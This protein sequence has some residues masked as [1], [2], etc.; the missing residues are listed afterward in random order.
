MMPENVYGA[1]APAASEW[2]QWVK[3]VLFAHLPVTFDASA[4]VL[5]DNSIAQRLPSS[6]GATALVLDLPG[7]LGAQMAGPLAERGYRPVP[8]YNS[9]P[10]PAWMGQSESIGSFS[11]S[12][13]GPPVGRAAVDVLPILQALQKNAPLLQSPR[14]PPDAPPAFLL[15]ANRRLGQIG[16]ISE[17]GAFDNR[18][19]SLPTD[20]PSSSFLLSRGIRRVV[21]AQQ[22]AVEPE[23]DLSHTLLRWQRAGVS[24]LGIALAPGKGMTSARS[25]TVRRPPLFRTAW[26]GLTARMG[27]RPHPL[28]GFGGL[29]PQAGGV[30]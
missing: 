6:D 1:W 17:P 12:E 26:Y 18:S 11:F 5:V 29:L 15:D 3:P 23:A 4:D 8:L 27:L 24:I 25:I 30:G 22:D 9:C 19:I 28:G 21:L 16:F 2:S 7:A 20:F 13:N 10:P 14:L